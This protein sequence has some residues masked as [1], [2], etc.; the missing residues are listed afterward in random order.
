MK[1]IYV[2][3]KSST[4]NNFPEENEKDITDYLKEL[5][6]FI[7]SKKGIV[8]NLFE[9][10]QKIRKIFIK[11][12]GRLFGNYSKY[13]TFMDGVPL[14]NKES[15]LITK[16][17]KEKGFY[18][19]FSESQLFNYFLQQDVKKAFPYFSKISLRFANPPKI[20]SKT[21]SLI[22]FS[23]KNSTPSISIVKGNQVDQSA[24]SGNTSAHK[25]SLNNYSETSSN[26]MTAIVD[27]KN[28][29]YFEN[30]IIPPYFI[31]ES[32]IKSNMYKIEE[33]ISLKFKDSD[34]S[35][36]EVNL[37]LDNFIYIDFKSVVTYRLYIIPD[38]KNESLSS[39]SHPL[40]KYD[41]IRFFNN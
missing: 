15:F 1:C 9:I 18:D 5:K 31:S 22:S 29:D 38:D 30:Y 34:N 39:L 6:K 8:F 32:I 3:L 2:Y 28:L 23:K 10:D 33:L 36:R 19:R 14:F 26:S 27:M 17:H 40:K 25:K 16:P 41:D 35:H 4:I 11:S 20:K 21:T 7:I 13:L 24:I 12:M 37:I